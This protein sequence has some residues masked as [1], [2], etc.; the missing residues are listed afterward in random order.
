MLQ[1]SGL[2]G[3]PQIDKTEEPKAPLACLYFF[4]TPP[5]IVSYVFSLLF[6]IQVAS[7]LMATLVLRSSPVAKCQTKAMAAALTQKLCAAQTTFTAVRRVPTA[8]QPLALVMWFV[9]SMIIICH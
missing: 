2:N 5:F 6:Q 7:V 9:F 8:I 3:D 4:T 1:D